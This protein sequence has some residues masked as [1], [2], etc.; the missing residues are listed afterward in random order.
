MPIAPIFLVFIVIAVVVVRSELGLVIGGLLLIGG[1]A[2]GRR[3]Q[4]LSA[5][6]KTQAPHHPCPSLC[7]TEQR[8]GTFA[9]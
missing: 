6:A 9:R 2:Y 1:V 7:E 4:M 5:A 8:L 3:A